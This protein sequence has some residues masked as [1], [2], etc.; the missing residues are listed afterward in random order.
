MPRRAHANVSPAE[1]RAA[2]EQDRDRAALE[3]LGILAATRIGFRAQQAA[4][5]ALRGRRDPGKAFRAE[6]LQAA[7]LIAQGML[8][9]HLSGRRRSAIIVA[10]ARPAAFASSA[11]D[12]AIRLLTRRLAL[13]PQELAGLTEKYQAAAIKVVKKAGDAAE[14][15]IERYL[16]EATQAGAHVREGRAALAEAF[17]ATGLTAENSFT[18]EAIFRTQTQLAY[19][20]GRWNLDQDPAVQEILWGYKYV[21]VGDDRVRPEHV[22]L[23]GVTLPK[24]DDFWKANWPPNGWACRCSTIEI[25]EERASVRAPASIEVDGRDVT[26]GADKGFRF[27]PGELFQD[28][29]PPALEAVAV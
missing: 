3:Q 2:V 16:L 23:E 8:A 5:A 10:Q 9:G 28:N 1:R 29:I 14:E 17:D 19:A 13:Q 12:G 24:D 6:W 21:T 27:N 18:L 26:P 11:Y 15:K 7:P 25:F 22:G 20:A 4:Y